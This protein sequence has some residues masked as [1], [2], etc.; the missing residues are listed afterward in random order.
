V[1]DEAT[2]RAADKIIEALEAKPELREE[3]ASRMGPRLVIC[4]DWEES[5]RGW[6]VRPDG[7]TLHL[8][9]EDHDAYVKGYYATYNNEAEAPGEYTRTSGGPRLVKV[10]EATYQRLR[11]QRDK[12]V[13]EGK[14]DLDHDWQRHGIWGHYRDP[15]PAAYR[16]E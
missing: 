5:E 2:R 8:S 13:G 7:H 16:G 10:A 12:I 11:V 3:V 14:E 4:Q 9:R 15:G 6:G 1:T